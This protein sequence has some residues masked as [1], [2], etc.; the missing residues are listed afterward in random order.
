MVNLSH[1]MLMALKLFFYAIEAQLDKYR[2]QLDITNATANLAH[3]IPNEKS[4]KNGGC[5]GGY[6]KF[7][8]KDTNYVV[9]VMA[10]PISE[11]VIV[12]L[13]KSVT[14]MATMSWNVGIYLMKFSSQL[15]SSNNQTLVIQVTFKA[16]III[17]LKVHWLL[18]QVM[19][20]LIKFVYCC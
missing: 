5:H 15:K 18:K 8:V 20:L 16:I 9:L 11:L 3:T 6:H 13:V 19:L 2:E 7:L 10:C 4:R 17:K 12:Q 1:W 14:S